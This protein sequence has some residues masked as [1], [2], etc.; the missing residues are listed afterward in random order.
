M[1]RSIKDCCSMAK[2]LCPFSQTQLVKFIH[3]FTLRDRWQHRCESGAEREWRHRMC[4]DGSAGWEQ[5]VLLAATTTTTDATTEG[6]KRTARCP[7]QWSILWWPPPT[8]H[9]RLVWTWNKKVFQSKANCP[10]P[11]ILMDYI[12][13]KFEHVQ[14]IP[15]DLWLTNDIMGSGHM[16]TTPTVNR[17][18]DKQIWLKTLPLRN[19]SLFLFLK[20]TA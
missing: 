14:G 1:W 18:V 15:C 19:S 3:K 8:I 12:V 13:K 7:Q 9:C 10:L 2:F 20:C 5:R 11:N 17:Q 6:R 16:G 4:G